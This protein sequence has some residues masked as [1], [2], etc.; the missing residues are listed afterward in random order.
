MGEEY[1]SL[2]IASLILFVSIAVNMNFTQVA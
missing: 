2:I 1:E